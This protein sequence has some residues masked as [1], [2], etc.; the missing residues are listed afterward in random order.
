M[1][2]MHSDQMIHRLK[3][4]VRA[5][6]RDRQ[7]ASRANIADTA[8]FLSGVDVGDVDL[9]GGN[10]DRLDRV[11]DRNARVR[12]GAGIDDD[13]VKV[14]VSRLDVVHE[15]A[16]VIGLTKFDPKVR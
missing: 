14:A 8:E 3:I 9:A 15:I 12:V 2:L 13:A 4:A 6:S 7:D 10:A 16:F 1:I 11:E 5:V